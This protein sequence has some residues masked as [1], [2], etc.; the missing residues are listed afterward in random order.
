MNYCAEILNLSLKNK[1]IIKKYPIIEVKKRFFGALKIYTI[2]VSEEIIDNAIDELQSNMSRNLNK[3]W[4]I[5]FH[6]KERAKIVFRE[7]TFDLSLNGIHPKYQTCLD[8]SKAKEKDIWDELIAYAKSLGVPD[9]Q[10]DFLPENYMDMN[11]D[12]VL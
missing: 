11:Y 10:C 2:L 12:I 6:T 5:T 1:K 7:K 3:E 9:S 8:T 4:Y